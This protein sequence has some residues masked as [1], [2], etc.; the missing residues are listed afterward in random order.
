MESCP[1]SFLASHRNRDRGAARHC[2]CSLWQVFVIGD[3]L[4]VGYIKTGL[5][6]IFAALQLIAVLSQR[7]SVR[8]L[9]ASTGGNK[10]SLPKCGESP[11]EL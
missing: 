6:W 8:V 1:Y 10:D 9:M 3:A 4:T 5:H 11:A 2:E 7:T